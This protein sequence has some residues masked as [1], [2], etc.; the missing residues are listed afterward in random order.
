[1]TSGQLPPQL[2]AAVLRAAYPQIVQVLG[3]QGLQREL[4]ALRARVNELE[5]R[6]QSRL[7]EMLAQMESEKEFA[8]ELYDLQ[9]GHEKANPEWFKEYDLNS[10]YTDPE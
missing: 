10:L 2:L 1:M 5:A 7:S 9:K 6:E 8:R 3:L 4:T